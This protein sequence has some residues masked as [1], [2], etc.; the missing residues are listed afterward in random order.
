MNE[1]KLWLEVS[2]KVKDGTN[3]SKVLSLS[4]DNRT[5][6]DIVDD[7]DFTI[8]NEWKTTAK[9]REQWKDDVCGKKTT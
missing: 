3:T 4:W 7:T 2:M 9:S 8:L 6:K 1:D 5:N